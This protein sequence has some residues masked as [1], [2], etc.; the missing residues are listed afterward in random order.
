MTVCF[1]T[2][3]WAFA[4]ILIRIIYVDFQEAFLMKNMV[5]RELVPDCI[6]V[7]HTATAF[8]LVFDYL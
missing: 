3:E 8:L 6:V 5:T 7:L 2:A 1:L 4:S